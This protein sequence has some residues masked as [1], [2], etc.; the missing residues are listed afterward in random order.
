[1]RL[2][3]IR[4]GT[5]IVVGAVIAACT[6]QRLTDTSGPSTANPA[7]VA[8]CGAGH[9]GCPCQ[10]EGETTACVETIAKSGD[11]VTCSTGLSVCT[12]GAWSRCTGKTRR[13]KSLTSKSLGLRSVQPLS[14]GPGPCLL[15]DGGPADECDPECTMISFNA[16]DVA[17]SP[18]AGLAALP[19]GALRLM[20]TMCTGLECQVAATCDPSSPT[21]LTGTVRD[22]A[23]VNP[24]YNALVYVP[25]DPTMLPPFASGPSCDQCANEAAVL[26]VAVTKTAADGTFTL[27]NVPSTDVGLGHDIPLVVQTGHWRRMQM[28]TSVPECVSTPVPPANS[29]L[30]T[31]GTDGANM[32]ADLPRI[33]IATGGQDPVEC[34]LLK[35][36][37]DPNEFQAGSPNGPGHVG[38]YA[39]TGLALPG[40]GPAGPQ[41]YGPNGDINSYDI[42]LLPCSG[43]LPTAGAN[44]VSSNA[45]NVADYAQNGGHVFAT[46]LSYAW[47]AMPQVVGTTTTAQAINPVTNLPNPFYGI[48][49]WNLNAP[50]YSNTVTTDIDQS[51]DAGAN[52]A[53]WLVDV[54]ASST[55]GQLPVNAARHDVDSVNPPAQRWIYNSDGGG[56]PFYFS[57]DT[58]L[59]NLGDGGSDGGA[60]EA[61]PDGAVPP[62]PGSCGRVEFSDFHVSPSEVLLPD[63]GCGTNSDCGFTT[64]CQLAKVG[65][66]KPQQCKSDAMCPTGEHCTGAVSGTCDPTFFC[67]SMGECQSGSCPNGRC[68]ASTGTCILNSDCGSAE[69]CN[70]TP[71]VC[72]ETCNVDSDCGGGELCVK[73][74]CTG[75]FDNTFCPSKVCNAATVGTCQTSAGTMSSGI[76]SQC[77]QG[78]LTGQEDALEFMLFNLTT[79]QTAPPPPFTAA[80]MPEPFSEIVSATCPANYHL[81]A[82]RQL[83]WHALIPSSSSISFSVQTASAPDDGGAI[84]WMSVPSTL[85]ATANI[86]SPANLP[87]DVVDLDTGDGGVFFSAMPPL[88]PGDQLRVTVTLNPTADG[89]KSPTL[90]SWDV[91]YDCAPT[92]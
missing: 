33:A 46:H 76:P 88:V 52:F 66:C 64:T 23:G 31:N 47:L 32:T 42:V 62:A 44:E 26:A 29:R 82:W 36:G 35:M 2:R 74:N 5:L 21:T 70:G 10:T 69:T 86:D 12:K 30:P 89:F 56:E 53:Q 60:P 19:D 37:I 73:G 50:P 11:Y 38:V 67:S 54:D 92:E 81:E 55:L 40:G 59:P 25:V 28:L 58:P 45:N 6:A 13:T 41:L 7:P 61:G 83:Q 27:T 43:Q 22:P 85:A 57:F 18:E 34:L 49:N 39:D 68:A 8:A 3:S 15:P 20:S 48:A 9:P 63:A 77:K 4:V 87:P 51:F 16:T 1:M 14:T 80:L 72:T 78:P 24:I 17:T 91:T 84:D 90:L 79:C 71:G 75:C 65:T